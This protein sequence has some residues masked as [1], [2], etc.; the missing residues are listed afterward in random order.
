MF[1]S[2][3]YQD[4]HTVEERRMAPLEHSGDMN[5]TVDIFLSSE[6]LS[7]GQVYVI[8]VSSSSW[9]TISLYSYYNVVAWLQ[10]YI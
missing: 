7:Q 2:S 6:E 3:G 9:G 1:Y 4:Y 10:V 8:I 5:D